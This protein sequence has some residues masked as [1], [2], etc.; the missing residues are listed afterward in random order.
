[1]WYILCVT[2]DNL[3]LDKNKHDILFTWWG[4]FLVLSRFLLL[5][6]DGI[7]QSFFGFDSY[8]PDA[9]LSFIDTPCVTA[10]MKSSLTLGTNCS[11]FFKRKN[12]MV[13]V[14]NFTDKSLS[15]NE[16]ILKHLRFYSKGPFN[17][18]LRGQDEGGGQMKK[19][20]FL[21]TLRV[22]KAVHAGMAKLC[23]RT[24]WMTL[25]LNYFLKT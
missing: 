23:P 5:R 12:H 4:R 22:K 10:F 14:T 21:S 17:N 2:K 7:F 24:C 25:N 11:L 18:Y 20:L 16:Y 6:F 13:V 19:C 9:L 1:M 8:A 15:W 3:V